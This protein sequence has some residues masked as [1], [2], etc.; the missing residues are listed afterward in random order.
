[1]CQSWES[2]KVYNGVSFVRFASRGLRWETLQKPEIIA[3]FSMGA[4]FG[5]GGNG[6]VLVSTAWD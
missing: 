2:T 3:F 4:G 5:H 1:M 6:E